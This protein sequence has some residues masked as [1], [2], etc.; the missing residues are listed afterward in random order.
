M[1]SLFR[2]GTALMVQYAHYHRDRR[3]IATHFVGI[4]MIVF[5]IG[6]L[7]NRPLW[8]LGGGLYATP[9]MVL[10]LLSTAWYLTR[11]LGLVGVATSV[12][13]LWLIWAAHLLMTAPTTT[14]LAWGVGAFV[15]GWVFQFVGHHWEGRKP[16]FAD[17]LVGLLVGP[18]F[19]VGEALFALG[20]CKPMAAAIEREAGPLRGSGPT[21]VT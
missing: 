15:L 21:T 7:L 12:V 14:W 13:N 18:A 2:D 19:V 3:N 20:L 4:P 9:G 16:A 11:G 6:V 8:A 5:A 10:W 1:A 17:D